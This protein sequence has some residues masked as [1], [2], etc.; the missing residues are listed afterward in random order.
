MTEQLS[1][2]VQPGRVHRRIYTDPA[3]FELELER[4]FRRCLDLYRA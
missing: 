2:F 4:I 1:R 3:I